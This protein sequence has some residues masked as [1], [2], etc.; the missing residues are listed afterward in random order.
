MKRII[1]RSIGAVIRN[2]LEAVYA[3]ACRENKMEFVRSGL[4][5]DI[6]RVDLLTAVDKQ[7][8]QQHQAADEFH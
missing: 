3:V 8:E 4:Q 5:K 2:A 7:A 1:A 6:S